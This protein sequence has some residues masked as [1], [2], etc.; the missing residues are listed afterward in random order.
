MKTQISKKQIISC[1]GKENII[2]LGYCE[3]CFLLE[4]LGARYYC[5]GVYG[6]S[7]DVYT[8]GNYA[9]TTGYNPFGAIR[10][11]LDLVEKYDK[12]SKRVRDNKAIKHY[13]TR[14]SKYYELL[15]KFIEEAINEK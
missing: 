7:C 5:A 12:L 3:L 4:A 10:P 11:S 1:Y 6:W 15:Q 9:I 14:F 2:R 13:N 8:L